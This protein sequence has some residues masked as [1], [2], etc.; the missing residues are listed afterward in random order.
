MPTASVV[1]GL[2]YVQM[3]YDLPD[4]LRNVSIVPSMSARQV[5]SKRVRLG[6]VAGTWIGGAGLSLSVPP[7]WL[8][9]V[10][11]SLFLSFLAGVSGLWS[12]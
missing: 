8:N 7:E 6:L 5:T 4:H 11:V 3:H 2:G 9:L 10:A 12:P 1:L